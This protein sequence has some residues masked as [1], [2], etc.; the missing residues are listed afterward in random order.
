MVNISLASLAGGATRVT[1]RICLI[2]N[3]GSR[4]ALHNA[5][6]VESIQDEACCALCASL[7]SQLTLKAIVVA[8]EADIVAGL[9]LSIVA[10]G[11]LRQ[12][13]IVQ[14]VLIKVVLA[15]C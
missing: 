1:R 5:G 4:G 8:L 14:E 12:A 13:F 9:E 15:A 7:G 2:V 11:T 10:L 3:C 6:A